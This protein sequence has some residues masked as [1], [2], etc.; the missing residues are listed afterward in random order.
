MHSCLRASEPYEFAFAAI[1]FVFHQS[2]DLV[3]RSSH[4][5]SCPPFWIN[6]HPPWTN[7]SR[8]FCCVPGSSTDDPPFWKSSRRRPWGRGCLG[9]LWLNLVPRVSLRTALGMRLRIRLGYEGD[10]LITPQLSKHVRKQLFC[11]LGY[12]LFPVHMHN[13]VVQWIWQMYFCK[14]CHLK[15]KG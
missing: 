2:Q 3:P 15:S 7:R 9:Y 10:L 4:S 1:L 14:M 8:E 13:Y 5:L 12:S 11:S 6:F